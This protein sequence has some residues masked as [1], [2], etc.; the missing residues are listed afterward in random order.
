MDTK[1]TSK[2]QLTLYRGWKSTGCYVWSP[3]VTK[4]ELRLRISDLVYDVS[5][6][7]VLNAPKG[8]IP[9]IAFAD[10]EMMAD[11]TL[12]TKELV[13]GGLIEDL[14]VYLSPEQQVFDLA[15]RSLLEDKLYFFHVSQYWLQ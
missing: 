13:K 7:S 15:I 6:G 3:Y 4:L 9:F 8:K 14:D 1:A 11:T 10:G 5:K 2:P 12:I